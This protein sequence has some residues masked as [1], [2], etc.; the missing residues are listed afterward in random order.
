[1]IVNSTLLASIR[2]FEASIR[3]NSIFVGLSYL[4]YSKNNYAGII[5]LGIS[6]FINIFLTLLFMKENDRNNFD[7]IKNKRLYI[8]IPLIYSIILLIIQII[9][10]YTMYS[11][12][13]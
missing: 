9:L 13:F 6:L 2:T 11:K 12:K 7:D 5:I 4:V 10:L 8:I 1:M 3:T